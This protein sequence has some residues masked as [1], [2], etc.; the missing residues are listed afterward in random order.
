MNAIEL[1]KA[2]NELGNRVIELEHKVNY[3]ENENDKLRLL[4]N[5]LKMDVKMMEGRK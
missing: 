5:D 4:L 2:V 3:L 1:T